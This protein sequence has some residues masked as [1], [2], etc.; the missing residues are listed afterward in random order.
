[1]RRCRA[2]IFPGQEDFGIVPVEAQACGAPV[3]AFGRGGATETVVP[4][5]EHRPGTGVLFDS[6]TSNALADA[7]T[8]FERHPAQTSAALA[9]RQACRFNAERYERELVAYLRRVTQGAVRRA[10]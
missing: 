2:L 9:R 8:W 4:A 5:D 10:A 3:I 6:Q 7:I 1:M